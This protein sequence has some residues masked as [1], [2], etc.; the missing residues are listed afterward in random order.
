MTPEIQ[1]IKRG[2]NFTIIVPGGCNANCGF[3][4]WNPVKSVSKKLWR[5]ELDAA[6]EKLHDQKILTQISIS[7]GEPT[8][9]PLL[10]ECLQAI[11]TFM[12]QK[13]IPLKVVLNTNGSR[14][15]ENLHHMEGVV[16]HVNISRHDCDD[17][18]NFNIFQ[19]TEVP[20]KDQLANI[21]ETLEEAGIDV[22]LNCVVSENFDDLNE[23]HGFVNLCKEVGAIRMAFR[24]DIRGGTLDPLPVEEKL[25]VRR[26]YSTCPVC[27]TS[28]YRVKGFPVTIKVGLDEPMSSGISYA[29]ELIYHPDGKLCL[30]WAGRLNIDPSTML[31]VATLNE[32]GD[33]VKPVS[34]VDI[35]MEAIRDRLQNERVSSG[36]WSSSRGCGSSSSTSSKSY[37]GGC[38][39]AGGCGSGYYRGCGG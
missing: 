37:S 5:K 39:S 16:N 11:R 25:G 34:S 38:G 23:V 22:T 21:C 28:E 7:G 27:S 9:S 35:V 31:E 3:C 12:A 30:D 18:E 1:Y 8:C 36:H 26:E 29:H 20:T 2:A 13:R 17:S 10:S 32:N 33:F 4:F 15:L 14:I 6:L 24:K 19:T